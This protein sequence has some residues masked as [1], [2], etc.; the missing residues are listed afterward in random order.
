[1][2]KIRI[3]YKN[4]EEEEKAMEKAKAESQTRGIKNVNFI[5]SKAGYIEY[6][7]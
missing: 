3:D 2:E 5:D 1:M 7:S 6:M 4:E